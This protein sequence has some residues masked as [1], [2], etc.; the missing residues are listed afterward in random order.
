MREINITK[1]GVQTLK[2]DISIEIE[3]ARMRVDSQDVCIDCL[4][5]QLLNTYS[6]EE[7]K[8]I[9]VGLSIALLA[10]DNTLDWLMHTIDVLRRKENID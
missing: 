3:C 2:Q 8:G 5:T 10:Y 6:I 9:Q 4:S 1:D 7:L